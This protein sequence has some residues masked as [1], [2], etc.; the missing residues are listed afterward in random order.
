VNYSGTPL[1][2]CNTYFY[3]YQ[4][5]GCRAITF[6]EGLNQDKLLCVHCSRDHLGTRITRSYRPCYLPVQKT[7]ITIRM[8]ECTECQEH[9]VQT[10]V[11]ATLKTKH[12]AYAHSAQLP[13]TLGVAKTLGIF[14]LDIVTSYTQCRLNIRCTIYCTECLQN[15]CTNQHSVQK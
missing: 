4:P 11:N 9:S 1:T 13:V 2:S 6:A 12:S 15:T 14:S 5:G 7:S 8:C 10:L 3:Q